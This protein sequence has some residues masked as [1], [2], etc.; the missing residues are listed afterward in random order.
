MPT[1]MT[2]GTVMLCCQVPVEVRVQL[3]GILQRYPRK[4]QRELI[5]EAL[6]D[7]FR[8]YERALVATPEIPDK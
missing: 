2:A 4:V 3:R 8:K 1:K 7:L 5:E 6:A